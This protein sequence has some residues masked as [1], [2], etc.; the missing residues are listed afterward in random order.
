MQPFTIHIYLFQRQ[1]KKALYFANIYCT[2]V[3][4]ML[5]KLINIKNETNLGFFSRSEPVIS[6]FF[7]EID[8][9]MIVS[10]I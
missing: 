6:E 5:I 4:S 1:R 9:G 2:V 7:E 8:C 10:K 3:E